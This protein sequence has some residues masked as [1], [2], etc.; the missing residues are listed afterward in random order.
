MQA[1][2]ST[3]ARHRLV[4]PARGRR[5]A[6]VAA[7]MGDTFGIDPNLIRIAFIVLAFASGVGIVLYLSAWFLTPSQDST[8]APAAPRRQPVRSQF[9]EAAA[10]GVIVVGVLLLVRS[11]GF[12]FA[13]QIVWPVMLVGF[14]AA[15]VWGRFRNPP[16]P[17]L[18]T[19]DAGSDDRAGTAWNAAVGSLVGDTRRPTLATIGRI[20]AG[21]VFLVTGAAVFLATLPAA[22][23]AR[24]AVS[25]L[26]VFVLGIGLVFGPWLL[27]LS[28]DLAEERRTRVRSQERAE[29]AAHLHDSVLHTL[30]LVRRNADDPRQ[31]V[32]LA[33][34]QERELR[35]WLAGGSPAPTNS[36]AVVLDDVAGTV[37]SDFGVPIEIVK[38]GDCSVEGPV[39]ALVSGTREA[40]VNAAKHSGAPSIAVYMEVDRDRVTVFVRDRGVGFEDGAV[41][42]DRRGI[43]D[44]IIG[45]MHRHG[46]TAEVRSRLGAGT[47]VQLSAPRSVA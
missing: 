40:M 17:S 22:T 8:S 38:V 35:T 6:G 34:R 7:G 42:A 19:P 4:R 44:S 47:E 36:L 41:E 28:Q 26:I 25:A 33:R 9:L 13:D 23:A 18:Q 15:L 24:T 5:I 10:L 31:V 3:E 20:G 29:I 21:C 43:A 27:R 32:G 39:E 14:G 46:G 37:E 16:A 12:A 1:S 30:A 2:L 45:R 11:S